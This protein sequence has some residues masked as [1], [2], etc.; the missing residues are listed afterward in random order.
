MRRNVFWQWNVQGPRVHDW[1]LSPVVDA[2]TTSFIPR[3]LAL[4]AAS[5][6][7]GSV[8]SFPGLSKYIVASSIFQKLGLIFIRGRKTPYPSLAGCGDLH[9]RDHHIGNLMAVNK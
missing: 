9:W 3:A 2:T 4:W 8:L 6:K 5:S 7:V 1:M